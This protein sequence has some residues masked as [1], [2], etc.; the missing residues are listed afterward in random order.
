MSLSDNEFCAT[1]KMQGF[2]KDKDKLAEHSQIIC[3]WI[4]D[5]QML[6]NIEN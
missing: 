2:E 4:S 1:S 5:I 3:E 6:L